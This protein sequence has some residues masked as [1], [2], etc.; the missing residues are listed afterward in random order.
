MRHSGTHNT[1]L[2]LQEQGTQQYKAHTTTVQVTLNSSPGR[3]VHLRHSSQGGAHHG[4]TTHSVQ[5]HTQPQSA[6]GSTFT[7]HV[8]TTTIRHPLSAQSRAHVAP[9]VQSPGTIQGE[10][11]L[12]TRLHHPLSKLQAQSR[13]RARSQGRVSRKR[14][15]TQACCIAILS[16]TFLL[17][18]RAGLV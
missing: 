8:S 2:Y 6:G 9:I 14:E 13:V 4:L 1:S 11:T 17:N 18:P 5:Q 3:T 15:A 16:S 12:P 7:T 10:S